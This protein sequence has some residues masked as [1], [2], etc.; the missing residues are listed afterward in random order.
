MQEPSSKNTKGLYRLRRA[1]RQHAQ[2]AGQGFVRRAETQGRPESQGP[3]REGC[4]HRRTQ[5]RQT[6]GRETCAGE[7]RHAQAGG[8]E[9]ESPRLTPRAVQ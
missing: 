4:H 1:D 2:G 5:G 3:G 8:G 7:G 6:R 9:E